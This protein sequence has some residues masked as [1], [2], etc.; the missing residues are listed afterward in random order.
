MFLFSNAQDLLVRDI[1][2]SPL[3]AFH[4]NKTNDNFNTGGLVFGI[5]MGF[6]LY[7]QKFRLQ[8]NTGSDVN[9]LGSSDNSF[10]SLNMLYEINPKIIDWMDTNFYAGLGLN[11]ISFEREHSISNTYFNL[12]LGTRFMFLTKKSI[13][14]GLQ[15]QSDFNYDN[16][17]L[18]YSTIIRFNFKN[19]S[20]TSDI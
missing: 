8:I 19:N 17:T 13:S 10:T 18:I 15:F 16:T 12:P 4:T 3:G 2:I 9:V 1:Q 5:D 11:H 14:L 20:K 7:K 6:E